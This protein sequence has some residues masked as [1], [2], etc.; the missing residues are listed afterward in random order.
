M[1]VI[2]KQLDMKPSRVFCFLLQDF[3]TELDFC[4]KIRFDYG[5]GMTL[6]SLLLS[7]LSS[8][9]FNHERNDRSNTLLIVQCE[10][11]DQC[12][13]LIAC[14][15]YRIYD[16]RAKVLSHAEGLTH[17]LFIIHLPP[18]TTGSSFVGYQGEPWISIHIDDL[19]VSESDQL[20]LQ[21]ALSH[22]ISELFSN[23]SSDRG[24]EQMEAEVAQHLHHFPPQHKRLYACVQAATSKL[25]SLSTNKERALKRLSILLDVMQNDKDNL[26]G[27]WHIGTMYMVQY[28]SKIR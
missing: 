3:G 12:G 22:K 9:S 5:I 10:S 28:C 15:R 19:R 13:D 7:S 21:D 20:T 26:L 2:T 16:E 6:L 27:M 8:T 24:Q 11:G 17:V 4:N 1:E 23:P 25:Q 18:H 14:A